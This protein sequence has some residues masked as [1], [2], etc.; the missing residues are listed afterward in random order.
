MPEFWTPESELEATAEYEAG[1]IADRCRWFVR[2]LKSRDPRLGLIY[3][4]SGS[5]TFPKSPRWAIVRDN[6]L[7]NPSYW[8]IEDEHGEFCEPQQ[9]HLDRLDEM[10]ASKKTVGPG[11]ELARAREAKQREKL[12]RKNEKRREFREKLLD[13]LNHLYDARVSVPRDIKEKVDA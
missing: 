13:R 6:E 11:E 7:I 4:K 2:E 5:T 3:I 10:D 9:R 12:G 1:R 8:M